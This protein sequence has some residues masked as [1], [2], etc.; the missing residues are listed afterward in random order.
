MLLVF[1]TCLL[2]VLGFILLVKGAGWLIEGAVAVAEKFRIPEIAI[3]LTVVAF[4][5]SAPELVVNVVS[6]FRASG[7]L[8]VGNIIGSNIANLAL[9]LGIAGIIAPLAIKKSLVRKEIPFGIL[10]IL[11]IYFLATKSGELLTLGRVG[12][13]VLLAG[14][15]IFLWV[16]YRM[17]KAGDTRL[18]FREKKMDFGMAAICVA[19]GLL[20]LA[21]GGELVVNSAV[22]IAENF[23]VSEKLIGLT[24]VAIGTSLPELVTSVLAVLKNKIDIAVG[25]VVGSNVFN[26]FWVLGVSALLRPIVFSAEIVTDLAVLAGVTSLLLA[27]TFFG[28]KYKL[29]RAE[30]FV[31]LASYASYIGFIVW[32]G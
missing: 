24:L 20:A 5:T 30:A 28:K 15:A 21:I 4:G 25:N 29:D 17:V 22:R 10:G 9:V 14:F 3:G 1:L 7:E 8:V 31:L 16:I 13:G 23:G 12:G 27:A 19:G 26:I 32:R 6:A 11:A 2:F 18:A